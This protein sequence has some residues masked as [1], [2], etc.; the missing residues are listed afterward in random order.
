MG[1]YVKWFQVEVVRHQWEHS[2]ICQVPEAQSTAANLYNHHCYYPPELMNIHENSSTPIRSQCFRL[3][4]INES[5]PTPIGSLGF[6]QLLNIHE[7][8]SDTNQ[9]APLS[10]VLEKYI[11]IG[12]SVV[13]MFGISN[14]I[15]I[16]GNSSDTNHVCPFLGYIS[17]A[18]C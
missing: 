14:L 11:I 6:R 12:N 9:R 16:H 2:N 8:S 3:L 4:N 17:S 13:M 5:S 1:Q 18:R 15:N 7:S 10:Y